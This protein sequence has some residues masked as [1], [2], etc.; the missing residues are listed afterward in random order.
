MDIDI[1]V[2]REI[3]SHGWEHIHVPEMTKEEFATSAERNVSLLQSHPS[4]IPF[5]AYTYGEHTLDSDNY[6]RVQQIVPVYIEGLRNYNEQNLI[7]RELL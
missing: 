4:Y 3:G 5:W 2:N 6:L 7:H 1:T